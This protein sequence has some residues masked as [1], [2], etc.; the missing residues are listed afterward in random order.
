MTGKITT[1]AYYTFIEALRNRLFILTLTGLV[2]LLGVAEFAGE[3]AVTGS[4]GIQAVLL[5]AIARWFIVLI[6]A[7]FVITSMARDFND[8]GVEMMLSLPLSRAAWYLGKYAGFAALALLVSVAVSLI[9]LLY[10][11]AMPL[12]GW[13]LSLACETAIMVSLSMLCMFTFSNVTVSFTVVMAFYLL[14]RSIEAIRLLS[15]SPILESETFSQ[16]FMTGLVN[17]IAYVLPDL[18]AY[19]RSDWLVY[20]YEDGALRFILLQTVIYLSILIPAGMFDLYRKA[21]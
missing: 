15:T 3:L 4:R 6:T 1:I 20:G 10:A 13:L 19:T 5:A 21:L 9:L 2:C 11:G 14:S 8:K 16:Q 7:L 17:A 18:D 12:L